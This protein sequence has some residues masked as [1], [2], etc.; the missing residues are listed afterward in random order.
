MKK[1][2]SVLMAAMMLAGLLA[3]AASAED[4]EVSEL[5]AQ[6]FEAQDIQAQ[7]D[8]GDISAWFDELMSDP[9]TH[10]MTEKQALAFNAAWAKLDAALK[11]LEK[12]DPVKL[13]RLLVKFQYMYARRL[14][15]A[16]EDTPKTATIYLYVF[17]FFSYELALYFGWN[18]WQGLAENSLVGMIFYFW[19]FGKFFAGLAVRYLGFGWWWMGG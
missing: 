19:N 3:A 8:I 13:E 4:F 15:L 5:A 11:D 17:D 16:E 14:K 1:L 7:E 6:E 2:L 9:G 18:V 12:E 10:T